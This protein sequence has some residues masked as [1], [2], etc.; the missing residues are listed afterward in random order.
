MM[1]CMIQQYEDVSYALQ[2]FYIIVYDGGEG[3]LEF[4][5]QEYIPV[6][7]GCQYWEPHPNKLYKSKYYMI[8]CFTIKSYEISAFGWWPSLIWDK[9][10]IF[11]SMYSYSVVILVNK[12]HIYLFIQFYITQYYKDALHDRIQCFEEFCVCFG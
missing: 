5:T 3:H 6:S 1:H 12:I 11:S 2:Q 8:I 7:N 9:E 10:C 4:R